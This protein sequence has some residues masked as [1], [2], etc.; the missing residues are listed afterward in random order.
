MAHRAG[1]PQQRHVPTTADVARD[2]LQNH[3]PR[4]GNRHPR[5]EPKANT[6]DQQPD[7]GVHPGSTTKQPSQKPLIIELR[8][9]PNDQD[10]I[11]PPVPTSPN[12]PTHRI[13]YQDL[14]NVPVVPEEPL[15]SFLTLT[16]LSKPSE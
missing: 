11:D 4:H 10:I 3:G 1:H 8:D 13:T 14:P 7:D 5:S 12:A 16:G 6:Q 9:I 2:T 15:N